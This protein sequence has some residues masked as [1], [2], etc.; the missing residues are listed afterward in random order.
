MELK[1][2]PFCGSENIKI[3]SGTGLDLMTQYNGRYVYCGDC[4][5]FKQ[6]NRYAEWNTRPEQNKKLIKAV[7]EYID[8]SLL[9]LQVTSA[10]EAKIV[11]EFMNQKNKVLSIISEI[12][13]V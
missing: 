2:C 10:Y 4:K 13:G 9:P 8:K 12:E 11:R 6:V 7:R 3:Q 1:P 5:A